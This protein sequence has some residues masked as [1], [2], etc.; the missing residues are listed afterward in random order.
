MI[1]DRL[2]ELIWNGREG[3]KS[4]TLLVAHT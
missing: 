3:K 4:V 2:Q 1:S